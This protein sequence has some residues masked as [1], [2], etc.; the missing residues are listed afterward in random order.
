MIAARGAHF[1]SVAL[2]VAWRSFH[3]F[4]SSRALLLPGIFFPL[5]FF[6]SFAGGIS[7]ITEVPGFD[8]P[9]GYTSFQYVFVLSQSAAFSGVFTGFGIARDFESG[10]AHRYMLA[11]PARAAIIA[12]YALA[13]LARALLV[14]S[15]ITTVALATGMTI[16]GSPAELAA[17]YA[18]AV[19]V[20]L[21][22]TLW[23]AGVALRLRSIQAGPM[24]QLPTFLVLFLAPVYVPLELLRGWIHTVAS[25]NPLTALLGAGR[26]LISGRPAATGLAFAVGIALPTVFAFWARGGLRRAEAAD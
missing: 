12:G 15:I 21:T 8:Y 26:G 7:A 2:A 14:W 5:I 6:A 13:S 22:G 1:G 18:L 11:S 4:L 10:F 23:A 24:M 20:N 17:L 9:G 19:L 3:N 16:D 25:V